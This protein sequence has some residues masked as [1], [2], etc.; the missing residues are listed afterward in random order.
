M[1][2]PYTSR[3]RW[4]RLPVAV[5]CRIEGVSTPLRLSELSFGGGYVDT[6]AIL[7]AGD[8]VSLVLI[9]DGEEATVSGPIIYTHPA[10]GFGFAFDLD[11]LPEPSRTR[12]AT[13]LKKSGVSETDGAD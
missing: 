8:R 4:P 11:E 10:M 2:E 13:F 3:R 9:I 12:I 7:T 5:E 6:T 1:P